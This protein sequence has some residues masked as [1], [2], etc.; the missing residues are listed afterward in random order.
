MFFEEFILDMMNRELI[1]RY[2]DTGEVFYFSPSDFDGLRFDE[3][4]FLGKEEHELS[5]FVYYYGDKS[6]DR[7]IIFDHGVGAGHRAY[8]KE[9]ER[10]CREGYTVISYDH[11]GCAKSAGIDI[12][13]FTRSVCDL[14]YLFKYLLAAD[15]YKDASFT[16]V[17]HSWGGFATLCSPAL[18]DK[19]THIVAIAGFISVK[20]ILSQFMPG[21]LKL[22]VPAM[23]RQEERNTSGYSAM[24][25]KDVL[26][27]SSVKAMIIHSEDD[28]TVK[29]KKH[30]AKLEK[31]LEDRPNT[32]FVSVT[33][34][35]HNPNYTGS[36]VMHKD[37]FFA[38][39]EDR[40]RSGYFTD[41]NAAA[42]FRAEFD[43]E[44]MTEQD[45]EI[46]AKI[47]EFLKS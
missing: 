10:I 42:K 44:K 21:P 28:P 23:L 34:K 7:Y 5:G 9:I 27:S 47:L 31:A 16:V 19:I 1:H 41:D 35:G 18:S 26:S 24:N 30:F 25:A 13:G 6:T 40:R 17:G 46:F 11:T 2:D 38:E 12:R 4:T 15:E 14:D 3:F 8:M 37:A 32:H 29:Y 43:F 36:A 45:E 39:L 22:Y 33:G 20:D